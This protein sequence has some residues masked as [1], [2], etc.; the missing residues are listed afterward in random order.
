MAENKEI[1]GEFNG[2]KEMMRVAAAREVG[3]NEERKAA[4]R[5]RECNE[6]KEL[7]VMEK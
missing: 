4:R 1:K 6:G 3:K 2:V 5:W 7:D